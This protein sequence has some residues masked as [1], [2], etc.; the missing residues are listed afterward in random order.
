MRKPEDNFAYEVVGPFHFNVVDLDIEGFCE[1][2]VALGGKQRSEIHAW[3][4]E[5]PFRLVYCEDP[6]GNIFEAYTHPYSQ[7]YATL[8][9]NQG[10]TPTAR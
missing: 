6:F 1:R 3:D 5:L 10:V 4:P 9:A 8:A 7:V 2:V